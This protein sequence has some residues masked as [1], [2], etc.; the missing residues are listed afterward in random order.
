MI[1]ETMLNNIN[2]IMVFLMMQHCLIQSLWKLQTNLAAYEKFH[3]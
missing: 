1:L 2:K 3:R